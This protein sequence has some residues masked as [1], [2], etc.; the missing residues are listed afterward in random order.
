VF[1]AAREAAAVNGQT[2]VLDGGGVQR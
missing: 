2:I 1:L